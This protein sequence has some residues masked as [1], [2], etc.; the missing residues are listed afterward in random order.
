MY[1]GWLY[2]YKVLLWYICIWMIDI[3]HDLSDE[4]SPRKKFAFTFEQYTRITTRWKCMS[5]SIIIPSK[6]PRPP[7]LPRLIHSYLSLKN[8]IFILLLLYE[9]WDH[10]ICTEVL[11]INI[12]CRCKIKFLGVGMVYAILIKHRDSII[13]STWLSTV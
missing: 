4:K 11:R 8:S 12:T 2:I 5:Y 7:N 1:N 13:T 10:E 6:V 9:N 3:F